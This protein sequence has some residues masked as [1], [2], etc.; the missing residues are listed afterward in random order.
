MSET[1]VKRRGLPFS[2]AGVPGILVDAALAGVIFVFFFLVVIPPH[3][4]VYDPLWKAAF[5]AYTSSVMAGFFWLFFTLFRVTL[6]DQLSRQPEGRGLA[7][8]VLKLM[9][10]R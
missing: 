7:S 3:V 2:L 5:S 8:K 4:P 9:Q 10:Y 6:R 1:E